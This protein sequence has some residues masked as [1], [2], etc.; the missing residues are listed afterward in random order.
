MNDISEAETKN[1]S[2]LLIKQIAI[3]SSLLFFGYLI[4]ILPGSSITPE[5]LVQYNWFNQSLIEAKVNII[6]FFTKPSDP[7]PGTGTVEVPNLGN[8]SRTN[9]SS[10]LSDSAKSIS[11]ATAKPASPT[12]SKLS[13]INVITFEDA[14]TQTILDGTTVSKMVEMSNILQDVLPKEDATLIKDSVN[15]LINNITD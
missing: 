3:Y 6:N 1:Q 14:S 2:D 10:S 8:I 9:S 5:E 15:K 7:N 4:F 13:P 11:E 12:I